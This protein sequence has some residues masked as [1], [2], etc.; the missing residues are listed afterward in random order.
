M[1][2]PN[3]HGLKPQVS[4]DSTHLPELQN[5]AV[6]GRSLP[7]PSPMGVLNQHSTAFCCSPRPFTPACWCMALNTGM[8][9]ALDQIFDCHL[10]S[11]D[12]EVS[13]WIIIQVIWY[14]VLG[15]PWW[16]GGF[17]IWRAPP[18]FCFKET[19]GSTSIVLYSYLSTYIVYIVHSTSLML[20]DLTSTEQ[21]EVGG[22]SAV[23]HPV[24]SSSE[25]PWRALGASSWIGRSKAPNGRSFWGLLE[26]RVVHQYQWSS[27]SIADLQIILLLHIYI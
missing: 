2:G 7:C 11:V 20:I 13:K 26:I 4:L 14:F 1:T 23:T 8:V 12:L 25:S 22:S 27:W 9:W 6:I 10:G 21:T 18:S 24:A 15:I 5:W 16:L 19:L 17:H 3:D